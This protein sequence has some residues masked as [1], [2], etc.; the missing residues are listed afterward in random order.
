M[1]AKL[2]S[3]FRKFVYAGGGGGGDAGAPPP[4]LSLW[5]DQWGADDGIF[6]KVQLLDSNLSAVADPAATCDPHHGGG[7][8]VVRVVIPQLQRYYLTPGA[9]EVLRL[10]VDGRCVFADSTTERGAGP[11][12]VATTEVVIHGRYPCSEE[13][14]CQRCTNEAGRHAGDGE[15]ANQCGWCAANSRCFAQP[16]HGFGSGVCPGLVS[17]RTNQCGGASDPTTASARNLRRVGVGVHVLNVGDVDLKAARFYA[18]VQIYLHVE[19][20]KDGTDRLYAAQAPYDD[21]LSECNGMQHYRMYKPDEDDLKRSDKGLFMV[22]IDRYRSV[23]MV[24]VNGT[25]HHYRV[26]SNFYFRTNVRDWPLQ[27]ERLELLMEMYEETFKSSPTMFFCIMPELSGLSQSVRF[28]GSLDNQRLSY[29]THINQTCSPPFLRPVRQCAVEDDEGT[30][31]EEGG[32]AATARGRALT[33]AGGGGLCGAGDGEGYDEGYAP[34]FDDGLTECGRRALAESHNGIF[35]HE[36][37]CEVV[38]DYTPGSDRE[39]CGCQGGRITSSR[40]SF[41]I[42]YET[43]AAGA[44]ISVYMAPAFIMV[45][46]LVTYSIPPKAVE[47]RFSLANSGLVSLVLFHSGLKSTLPVTGILTKADYLMIACYLALSSSFVITALILSLRFNEYPRTAHAVFIWSRILGPFLTILFFLGTEFGQK[48]SRL[49]QLFGLAF[50]LVATALL[51]R[52]CVALR[53]QLRVPPDHRFA[54]LRRL[55]HS[56]PKSERG[57]AIKRLSR[58]LLRGGKAA[59]SLVPSPLRPRSADPQSYAHLSSAASLSAPPST[60]VGDRTAPQIAAY[61]ARSER[62]AAEL[63]RSLAGEELQQRAVVE[64]ESSLLATSASPPTAF[65]GVPPPIATADSRGGDGRESGW[66]VAGSIESLVALQR[67]TSEQMGALQRQLEALQEMQRKQLDHARRESTLPRETELQV[68]LPRHRSPGAPPQLPQSAS[69]DAR[70]GSVADLSLSSRALTD[71]A[72]EPADGAPEA[73]P[74]EEPGESRG[75]DE[76][77]WR[78]AIVANTAPQHFAPVQQHPQAPY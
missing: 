15:S 11:E 14:S 23:E 27:T 47:T 72:E 12:A 64:D 51:L 37:R 78:A 45:I 60:A 20:N 13:T 67:S 5:G 6:L 19:L 75:S 28:P 71:G 63:Y 32:G 46:A 9:Q 29:E 59:L 16:D 68:L 21:G 24:E 70:L 65:R 74:R 73:P 22:N 69:V 41:A 25:L 62:E 52:C 3:G 48:P 61:E 1:R 66:S 50:G 40:L 35:D 10:R 76:T 2:P 34:P 77:G 42:L 57:K 8:A 49:P 55:G 39:S 36:C 33:A 18:D 44:V 58:V 56:Q 30:P 43:P 53:A 17:T 38:S 7:C 4:P 31:A 54:V 26:Q